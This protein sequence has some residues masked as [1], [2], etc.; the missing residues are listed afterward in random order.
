LMVSSGWPLSVCMAPYTA[1]VNSAICPSRMDE[2][3]F[4][5]WVISAR[6]GWGC[7]GEQCEWGSEW[8]NEWVS[9]CVWE[10]NP[11]VKLCAFFLVWFLDLMKKILCT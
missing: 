8:V 6:L 4:S 11:C 3:R 2:L 5:L 1:P 7:E 9:V 10:R